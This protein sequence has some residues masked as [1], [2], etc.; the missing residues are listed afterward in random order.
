MGRLW[1]LLLAGFFLFTVSGF[2]SDLMSNGTKPYA[3]VLMIATI[4]GLNACLWIIATAR[5][6]VVLVVA[7]VIFQFFIGPIIGWIQRW[8]IAY[9]ALQPVPSQAGIH[10][11]ATS[12]F[13]ASILSYVFFFRYI[14]REGKQSIRTQNE[15]ELAHDIQKSLVP[16][17]ELRTSRFEIYGTSH[18][19]DSVGGDL[20]DAVLL[21]NGDVVAYLADIT[22]HG[23]AASILMGRVK[24]AVRTALLDACERDPAETIPLLLDRLNTVLPQVKESNMYATFTGFRLGEDGTIFGGVAAGTPILH[25]HSS[26]KDLSLI[27][28]PQF[29]IGLLPVSGFEGFQLH[30]AP[31]DILVVATD[32]ILEVENKESEQLGATRLKDLIAA[33]A[34]EPLPNIARKMLAAAHIFGPQLDDQTILIVRCL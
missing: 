2:Y 19:S 21:S 25:W 26:T 12:M 6:P 3:I 33:S 24:T 4:S 31:D 11:A 22:G 18:P 8:M 16:L 23:L 32:G 13:W 17:L 28:E 10:F 34:H 1:A 30:A 27:S 20:V 5:F 29:P 9:F 14:V 15:L 7:L